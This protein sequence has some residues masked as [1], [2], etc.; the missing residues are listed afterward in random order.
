MFHEAQ[1]HP[2]YYNS[3]P[4]LIPLNKLQKQENIFFDIFFKNIFFRKF[5]L[6]DPL[7]SPTHPHLPHTPPH[8]PMSP[9]T[10]HS[11]HISQLPS[12]LYCTVLFREGTQHSTG[13][14][15]RGD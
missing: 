5:P 15:I 6:W 12:T 8:K 11:P 4:M 10:T 9:H 13:Q 7:A 14:P 2:Y 1:L 3:N